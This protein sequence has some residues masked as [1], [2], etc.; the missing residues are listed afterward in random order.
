MEGVAFAPS[1]TPHT[2]LNPPDPRPPPPQMSVLGLLLPAS[3]LQDLAPGVGLL[4]LW[5]AGA[6]RCRKAAA[7]WLLGPARAAL[8]AGA[9]VD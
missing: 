5:L 3:T 8:S 6:W 7:G 1:A 2:L 4:A 9:R